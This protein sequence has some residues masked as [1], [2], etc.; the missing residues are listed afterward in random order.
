MVIFFFDKSNQWCKDSPINKYDT[1][2]SHTSFDESWRCRG[3]ADELLQ[4]Y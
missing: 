1:Y 2:T 4:K 3:D